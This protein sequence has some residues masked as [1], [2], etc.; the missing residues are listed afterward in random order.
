VVGEGNGVGL[1]THGEKKPRV[2]TK[3]FEKVTTREPWVSEIVKFRI[4]T[5]WG[6]TQTTD[7]SSERGA[8]EGGWLKR[9]EAEGGRGAE[10][11][12]RL[13]LRGDPRGGNLKKD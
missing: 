3:R 1:N 6:D 9:K 11:I 8:P 5:D 10:E 7:K 2:S 12:G 13:H 4:G